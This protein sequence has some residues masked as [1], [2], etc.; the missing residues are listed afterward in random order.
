MFV[1]SPKQIT[2]RIIIP[3]LI[4]GAADEI[5]TVQMDLLQDAKKQG[6][7]K[8]ALRVVVVNGTVFAAKGDLEPVFGMF[9]SKFGIGSR[10]VENATLK[11]GSQLTR[12]TA[13]AY[14]LLGGMTTKQYRVSKLRLAEEI[15]K[16]RERD[17]K[18]QGAGMLLDLIDDGFITAAE[19]KKLID[20]RIREI[21]Q[22]G[23]VATKPAAE[24]TDPL[25][26]NIG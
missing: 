18:A 4:A 21:K 20:K 13:E 25:W 26:D 22:Q 9:V 15:R 10:D 19:A 1:Q 11:F 7:V 17:M 16:E 8:S 6:D 2:A 3:S 14:Y 12:L 24:S 23:A 5:I